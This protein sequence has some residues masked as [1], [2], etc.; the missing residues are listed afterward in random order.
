MWR[1]AISWGIQITHHFANST[2]HDSHCFAFLLSLVKITWKSFLLCHI[3]VNASGFGKSMSSSFAITSLITGLCSTLFCPF[4][5]S[6]LAFRLLF[7]E[8]WQKQ[9]YPF[10]HPLRWTSS[11]I[12]REHPLLLL[13]QS[14]ERLLLVT[15]VSNIWAVVFLGTVKSPISTGPGLTPTLMPTHPRSQSLKKKNHAF[16]MF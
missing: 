16:P 1:I 12:L 13:R 5:F 2:L 14:L 10:C 9:S 7:L 4:S 15:D 11:D 8:C 3:S 6:P